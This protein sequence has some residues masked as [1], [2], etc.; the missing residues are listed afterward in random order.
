MMNQPA[1]NPNP[2][3]C[4]SM[5]DGDPHARYES[6]FIAS[7]AA[8]SN[9]K[10]DSIIHSVVHQG[11][12]NALCI[13]CTEGRPKRIGKVKRHKMIPVRCCDDKKYDKGA[14]IHQDS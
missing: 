8:L 7:S 6:E 14:Y 10:I 1:K 3:V 5:P 13:V 11:S 9:G 2:I 4:I 12:R